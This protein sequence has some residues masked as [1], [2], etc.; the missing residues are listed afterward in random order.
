[1]K[2]REITVSELIKSFVTTS[3]LQEQRIFKFIDI[4]K[5]FAKC[6]Q[7]SRSDY[8]DEISF[9]ELVDEAERVVDDMINDGTLSFVYSSG[10]YGMYRIEDKIDYIEFSHHDKEYISDMVRVF[11]AIN[12]GNPFG[13]KIVPTKTNIKK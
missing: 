1:M 10:E 2:K 12:G 6:Y 5:Y 3:Y 13:V 8:N 11:L 7:F 4:W 9:V